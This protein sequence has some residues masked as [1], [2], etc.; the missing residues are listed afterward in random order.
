MT[1]PAAPVDLEFSQGTWSVDAARYTWTGLT[2]SPCRSCH[3][4]MLFVR[5]VAN[6][7]MIPLDPDGVPHFRTCPQA[8]RWRRR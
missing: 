6:R 2:P 4:P 3:A 7:R 1:P 5:T 8:D